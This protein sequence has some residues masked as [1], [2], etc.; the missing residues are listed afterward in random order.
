M[1]PKPIRSFAGACQQASAL[2]VGARLAG[3]LRCT[4]TVLR[5]TNM[6]PLTVAQIRA[7]RAKLD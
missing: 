5:D 2:L 1:N 6:L 4:A 3:P 7:E